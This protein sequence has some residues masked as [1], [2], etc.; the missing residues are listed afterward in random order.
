MTQVDRYLFAIGTLPDMQG[1]GYGSELIRRGLDQADAADLEC[2]L[3]SSKEKN[4]PFCA[5]H[6]HHRTTLSQCRDV[7][8]TRNMA[9]SWL[10]SE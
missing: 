3:E 5:Y 7:V 1:K 9:L 8:Q 10:R 6:T 2:W 4:I